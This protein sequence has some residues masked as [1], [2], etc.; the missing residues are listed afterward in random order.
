MRAAAETE[1]GV[2]RD[3]LDRR[4]RG[5]AQ[6]HGLVGVER[7]GESSQDGRVHAASVQGEIP[8][9]RGQPHPFLNS[10]RHSRISVIQR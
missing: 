8:Y 3:R 7:S 4:R 6:D 2:P 1:D 5:G 10:L 9:D